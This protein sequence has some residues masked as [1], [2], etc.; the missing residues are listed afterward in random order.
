MAV[1]GHQQLWGSP[2]DGQCLLTLSLVFLLSSLGQWLLLRVEGA[3]DHSY[4][5]PLLLSSPSPPFP[6]LMHLGGEERIASHAPPG[7]LI[8]FWA[9]P[10]EIS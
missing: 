6:R 5:R 4:P 10:N 2:D 7:T 8:C 3:P 1:G 9:I